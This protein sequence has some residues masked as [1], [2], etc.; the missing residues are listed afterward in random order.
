MSSAYWPTPITAAPHST[1]PAIASAITSAQRPRTSSRVEPLAL[2]T[3]LSQILSL[4]AEYELIPAN[5]AAGKRRRVKGTKPRRP[6]VEP[7][8]L[9]TLLEA[10]T[11]P[12]PLL[13]GRGR[14]LFAVLAGAGLRIDEALSLERQS[15]NLAKATLSV[16]KSKTEAGVRVVD[17]TPALR[18]EL[19]NYL[20]R[21]P[22]RKPTDLV[23]PTSSGRKDNRQNVRQRLFMKAI[24][25]ANVRLAELGIDPLG[26]VRP[27]GLR[28]TYASL[29]TACGDDTVFVSRQIGHQDVRFTLNVYA[30]SVKRRERMTEA[31]RKEYDRAIEWASW[32]GS[33]GTSAQSTAAVPES[34]EVSSYEKAPR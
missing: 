20:D 9:L 29:R 14:P 32:A 7:E 26:D 22:H 5:P 18:D 31:E 16:T 1:T 24:T 3:R 23:F 15:V 30:Q 6:W 12:K 8:Q 11:H 4:A 10:A 17:L 2:P 34:E 19:A 21:S 27:H 25:R 28:R 13:G 33:M